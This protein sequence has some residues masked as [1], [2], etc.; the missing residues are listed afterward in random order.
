MTLD[1]EQ[2]PLA[3][4]PSAENEDEKRVQE[5]I[6]GNCLQLQKGIVAHVRH[7][8]CGM[9]WVVSHLEQAQL[10]LQEANPIIWKTYTV[11]L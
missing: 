2:S 9:P 5:S 8:I 11:A 6:M 4:I 1:D 3:C 7:T 10:E